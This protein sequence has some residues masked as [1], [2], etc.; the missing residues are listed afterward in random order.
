[1][2][3]KG[4]GVTARKE[5]LLLWIQKLIAISLVALLIVPVG[6]HL[7]ALPYR[8]GRAT[9]AAGSFSGWLALFITIAVVITFDKV[10]RKPI[11]VATL[12]ASLLAAGSLAAFGV[13]RFGVCR[14]SG[15]DVLLGA[16]ILIALLL[17][18]SGSL[19]KYEWL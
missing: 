2:L 3:P 17:L 8:V 11:S 9:F 5:R 12:S 14:W 15:L 10:F 19:F 4:E 1:P 18:L 6:L 16:F 7:I 13:A